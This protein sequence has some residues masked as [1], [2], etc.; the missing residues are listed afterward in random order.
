MALDVNA[1]VERYVQLRDK[2]E[3]INRIAKDQT[4]QIEDAMARLEAA[5]LKH[6]NDS[7]SES[8]GTASGTAFIK[9]STSATVADFDALLTWIRERDAW[10]FLDKRV[11]KTAVQEFRDAEGDLPPGVTWREENVVQVRRS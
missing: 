3:E 2:K 8:I 11:N 9:K 6:L 4:K 5:L 10:Q 7:G 1:V